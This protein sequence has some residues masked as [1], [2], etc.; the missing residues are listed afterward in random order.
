MSLGQ[1]TGCRVAKFIRRQGHLR[2]RGDQ[3]YQRMLSSDSRRV[4]L[5]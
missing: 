1:I 5:V 3:H 2:E 4:S